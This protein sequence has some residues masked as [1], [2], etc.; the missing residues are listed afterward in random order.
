[1]VQAPPGLTVEPADQ[2]II[3]EQFPTRADVQ[4]IGFNQS[5][6]AMQRPPCHPEQ[7]FL[8]PSF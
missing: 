1:M 7:I 4:R 6:V 8:H 3:N 5:H 2:G